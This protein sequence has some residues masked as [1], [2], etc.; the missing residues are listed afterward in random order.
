M[1]QATNIHKSYGA[2]KVLQGVDVSIEKGEIVSIVGKS[3]AGKSTL[4]HILGT[5]DQ[6]DKG[7]VLFNGRDISN[8]DSKEIAVFRNEHIGFI[9]QFHHLLPEF[10]AL[11]NVCIPA[12]I[13]K[14]P[15][16][17]V[18]KKAKELLA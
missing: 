8:L 3:G 9:F 11:E 1:L 7:T 2:L 10:N 4:L 17:E 18:E 14:T 5:L 12:F 13:K 16:A 6:A 15:I